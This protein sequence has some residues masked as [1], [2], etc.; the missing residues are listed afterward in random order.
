MCDEWKRQCIQAHP[1]DLA[2]QNFCLSFTCGSRNATAVGAG[3]G[4]TGGSPASG[5]ASRSA[6]T[7]T[8]SAS[9]TPNAASMLAVGREYGTGV[10]LLTLSGFFA[11]AL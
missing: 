10:V 3:A 9:S 8:P 5:S 11:F 1:N 4:S 2:G 7:S 6:S